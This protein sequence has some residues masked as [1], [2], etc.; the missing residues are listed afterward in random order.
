MTD[1]QT[2]AAPLKQREIILHVT[3]RRTAF[4]V[5]ELQE[6]KCVCNWISG[7]ALLALIHRASSNWAEPGRQA[8]RTKMAHYYW[9]K[10]ELY[11]QS[12]T[13]TFRI[14]CTIKMWLCRFF[15]HTCD[16]HAD[17]NPDLRHV[18]LQFYCWKFKHQH[19]KLFKD[20]QR[21]LKV[22]T[23]HLQTNISLDPV[24]IVF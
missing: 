13:F 18:R 2:T 21:S 19:W 1:C 9:E 16:E 3:S 7:A 8:W 15:V 11:R 24:L 6:M 22:F 10:T 23:L 5:K 14:I 17:K 20:H 4:I 12:L